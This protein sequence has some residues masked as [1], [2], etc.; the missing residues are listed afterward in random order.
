MEITRKG[1]LT[2]SGITAASLAL[3]RFLEKKLLEQKERL[4]ERLGP[5]KWTM[6]VC[7]Q[8]SAACG[9]KIRTVSGRPMGTGEVMDSGSLLGRVGGVE[10]NHGH[11]VNRGTIC[12]LGLTASHELYHPDRLTS[13]MKRIGP[14]GEGK[15]A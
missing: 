14:R 10:G 8:C 6:T 5:E 7:A 4:P 9:L 15:W 2:L 1:F 3:P 12:P 11:P 13:P